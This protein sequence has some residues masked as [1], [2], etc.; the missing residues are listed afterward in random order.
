MKEKSFNLKIMKCSI[1][2]I[3]R[4][5]EHTLSDTEEKLLSSIGKMVGNSYDTYELFK[6]CDMS[7]DRY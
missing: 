7:F 4:Y 3:Y 2:E 6:D 5:K 1:K